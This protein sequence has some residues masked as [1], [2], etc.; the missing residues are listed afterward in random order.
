MRFVL[1]QLSEGQ[2]QWSPLPA[3]FDAVV[4][5]EPGGG[6]RTVRMAAGRGEYFRALKEQ[7][8]GEGAAIDE[9][10]RLLK[11]RGGSALPWGGERRGPH[12]PPKIGRL[13][14]ILQL[15]PPR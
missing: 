3:A 10:Q 1:D 12:T 9:F 11:V 6:A 15:T 4:L 7:F 13:K 14:E 2:L 5:G 8:P